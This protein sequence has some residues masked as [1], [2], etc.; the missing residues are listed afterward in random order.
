MAALPYTLSEGT[1][2]ER[3][4]S[5]RSGQAVDGTLRYVDLGATPWYRI[6][7]MVEALDDT[8]RDGLMAFLLT[9]KTAEIDVTIN[10]V[11]Y[12]G[13]LLPEANVRWQKSQGRST[14]SFTLQARAV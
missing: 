10:S 4:P 2:L 3:M 14:V 11:V 13:R 6:N 5:V 8:D 9:N 1:T 12:R 7:C